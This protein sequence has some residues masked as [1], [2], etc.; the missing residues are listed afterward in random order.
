MLFR[1]NP[2][3]VIGSA[4]GEAPPV[5][6]GPSE[7]ATLERRA[8]DRHSACQSPVS[9][10]S[11]AQNDMNRVIFVCLAS[12]FVLGLAQTRAGGEDPTTIA[13]R[14]VAQYAALLDD[15]DR[16][17][18]LRA[19]KSLGA[20]G[21][22]AGEAIQKT[23]D[24]EDA[25]MRFTAAVHLGRIGGQPLSDA[26]ERLSELAQDE[27]SHAVRMAA[28]YALCETGEIKDHLPLLTESLS[29]PERGMACT[30]AELIGRLGS[31]AK[32][33]VKPLEAAYEKHRPGAK[34]GDYHIGGAAKN[35]LRKIRG[36]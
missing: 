6:C 21:L 20:F 2:T 10:L 18:R 25:A 4:A 13:G 17:V 1:V 19:I 5:S 22:S 15:P 14:T 32:A 24:H 28:C 7:S 27:S 31:D 23:L 30:A 11:D 3:D 8:A 26:K 29:Y 33:A 9:Y 35:A 36:E 16:V 34:G 12:A